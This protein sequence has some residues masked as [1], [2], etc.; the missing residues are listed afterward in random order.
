MNP[1]IARFLAGL[2]ATLAALPSLAAP[3]PGD[4]LAQVTIPLTQARAETGSRIRRALPG[5]TIP[6]GEPYDKLSAEQRAAFRALFKDLPPDNDPPYPVDGLLPIAQ[7]MAFALADGKVGTGDLFVIVKVDEKGEPQSTSVY[8]TP[9]ERVA[10][11]AANALM[12]VKYRPGTCAG[13]PCTSE[14]PFTAKFE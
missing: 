7:S 9:D 14:F 11:E 5:M 6:A 3:P 8:A 2:A 12:R 1:S 10:K 4:V 13:K